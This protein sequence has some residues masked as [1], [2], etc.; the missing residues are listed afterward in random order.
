MADQVFNIALGRVTELY[1]RVD[2]NDP[3]N[4]VLLFIVYSVVGDQD[5]AVKDVTDVAALEAL[6]NVAEVTNVGSERKILTDAD[7]VAFAP[8]NANNRIDLD[9]PDQT[10]VAVEAGDIWSD[11]AICYDSDSTGGIDAGIV[12]MTWHDFAVTPNGGDI[13]A[14]IFVDGFYRAS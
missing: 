13:T 2:I 5:A 9:L 1:N 10:W 7:L 6:A 14:Q 12:T 3:A 8:D 4:S 11:I